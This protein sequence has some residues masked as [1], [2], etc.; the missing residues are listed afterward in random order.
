MKKNLLKAL[1]MLTLVF[2]TFATGEEVKK[3]QIEVNK[4]LQPKF[5]D[6]VLSDYNEGKYQPFLR[7]VHE[8][9]IDANKK[10]EYNSILEERKKLSTVVQDFDSPKTDTFKKKIA[11]LQEAEN[12]EIA[13]LCI[14]EPNSV[15]IRE[16]KDMLFFTPSQYE[17]ESLQYLA[18]LNWKFKGDGKT[19]LENKLIEIDTEFWLKSLSLDLLATQN[20]IDAKTYEKRSAVLHL[21]K[22]RQMQLVCQDQEIHPKIRGYIETAKKI[23]PK[24]HAS[25]LTR[26]YLHNLATG[27]SQ[28]QN[29]TEAKLQ[30]IVT[31]YHLKQQE[32]I[33]EYFPEEKN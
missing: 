4:S 21:E 29:Q 26:K 32:L 16:I 5:M 30:A 9:Y 8:S 15:L 24:V 23:Y 12:R 10:W 1:F 20:K 14:S 2:S 13:D 11:K 18:N 19:P 33:K 3:A 6:K 25:S 7:Q 28:P 17:Q 31:R 27:K 22:L